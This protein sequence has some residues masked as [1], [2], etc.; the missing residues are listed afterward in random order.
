M[1]ISLRVQADDRLPLLWAV[2][3]TLGV[4]GFFVLSFRFLFEPT[5]FENPRLAA[6]SAPPETRLGPLLR[7]SDAPAIADLP[8]LPQTPTTA[9]AQAQILEQAKP[10]VRPAFRRQSQVIRRQSDAPRSG[11]SA[12]GNY[13][14]RDW[15]SSRAWG[16]GFKG[17]F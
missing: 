10:E 7:Q 12:Q 17:W 6:Y 14:Y 3:T 11:Y 4:I 5:V 9:V 1:K 15:S 16:S 2:G 8:E 13:A